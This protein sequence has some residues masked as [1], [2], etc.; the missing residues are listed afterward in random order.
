MEHQSD[1]EYEV[2]GELLLCLFIDWGSDPSL[3][4]ELLL[5]SLYPPYI[6]SYSGPHGVREGDC[7]MKYP[8][9]GAT[10]GV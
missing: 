3:S 6:P 4:Q 5:R 10:V 1:E 2:Q 7:D 9:V 8:D